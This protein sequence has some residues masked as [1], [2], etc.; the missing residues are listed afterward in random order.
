MTFSAPRLLMQNPISAFVP[1]RTLLL[2]AVAASIPWA[3]GSSTAPKRHFIAKAL[4]YIWGI[5]VDSAGN[6]YVTQSTPGSV[7]PASPPAVHRLTPAGEDVVLT[8]KIV[9]PFGVAV[10]R[11]DHVFVSDDHHNA[12]YRVG[13]DGTLVSIVK[14]G[15]PAGLD[16]ATTLAINDAGDVFVGD[17]HHHVI[18]RISPDGNLSTFA[19]K[20]GEIAATDGVGEEARFGGPRGIAID[21]HG[22]LYVA[23]EIEQNIRRIT[24]RAEVSTLAGEVKKRGAADGRGSEA[25]FAAPRGLAV[26]HGGN[27]FVADADNDTIRRITPDGTVT[28]FAGKTGE[29]G[30]VDGRGS[31]AR[32]KQPRALA[33][34]DDGNL[35][36][37]DTGNAAIREISP[38]GDVRTVVGPTP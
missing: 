33:V 18:R 29:A 6:L 10:D 12:V 1:R 37:A 23:D 21:R 24:P 3:L 4:P 16:D 27:V 34:D 15:D 5:A 8:T 13:L 19:G 9:S 7:Q 22:N 17:N 32:F 2:V 36:V 31:A 30:L 26:D 35:F 11:Q 28:T 38:S 25:Q 14:S 20:F